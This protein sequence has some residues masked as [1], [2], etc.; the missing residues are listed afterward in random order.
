[1]IVDVYGFSTLEKQPDGEI[2]S[3]TPNG[4]RCAPGEAWGRGM[5]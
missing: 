5:R 1:M 4:V 2:T 3:L